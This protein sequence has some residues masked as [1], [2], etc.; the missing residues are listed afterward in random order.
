MI[1][2]ILAIL[3]LYLFGLTYYVWDLKMCID[4]LQKD[5]EINDLIRSQY[6]LIEEQYETLYKLYMREHPVMDSSEQSVDCNMAAN[7]TD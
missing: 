5:R 3:L 2:I 1:Y 7:T 6:H 4:I